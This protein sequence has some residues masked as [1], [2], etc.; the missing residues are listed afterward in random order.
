MSEA[1]LRARAR[2]RTELRM[3]D[4][5][6]IRR[7]TG[8]TVDDN[9][10]VITPT[11]TALYSGPCRL[12]QPNAEAA[13]ANVGEAFVLLQQP[14][15]HLPMSADVLRP[16]DEITITASEGDAESVG[17]IFLVRSVPAHSDAS[18]RRYGVTERTS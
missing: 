9:T 10:G 17:R 15:V 2:A 14:E 16:S 5:C 12:K 6:T 4:A 18:A 11:W 3:S 8:E 1:T 13:N 7:Q